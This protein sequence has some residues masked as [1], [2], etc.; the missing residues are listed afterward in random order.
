LEVLVALAIFA[1]VSAIAFRGLTLILD[2]RQRV[3]EEGRKWQDLSRLH[4]RLQQDFSQ[5]V[6]R[7]VRNSGGLEMPAFF[8]NFNPIGEEEA[9]FTFTRMGLAG[10]TDRAQNLQRL[11]YRLRGDKIQMLSWASLDQAPRESPLVDEVLSGVASL[12]AA[13]LDSTGVW[14]DHWPTQGQ[15]IPPPRAVKLTLVLTTGESILWQLLIQ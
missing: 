14:Q 1:L 2:T 5:I 12:Q 15:Y 8:G 13:Y 7:P 6:D 4:S 10:Q 9:L 3:T 11:G